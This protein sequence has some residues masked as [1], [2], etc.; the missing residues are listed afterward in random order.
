[1]QLPDNSIDHILKLFDQ[2]VDAGLDFLKQHSSELSCPVPGISAVKLLCCILDGL[3]RSISEYYGGFAVEEE[4]PTSA[5]AE[6]ETSDSREHQTLAGIYIPSKRQNPSKLKS[7]SVVRNDW[8]F[9]RRNPNSLCAVISNLFVFAF[10][11]AFG[12]SFERVETEVDLDVTGGD[13]STNAI[14]HQKIARGGDTAMEKFDALVYDLF[15]E[16]E[17]SVQ[18][19][20]TV[21]MIYSYYPN[22][23]NN[24]FEPLERLISS[25]IQNVSFLSSYVESPMASQRSLFNLFSNPHEEP[26]NAS[27]LSMIPTADTIRLSFLISVIFESQYMPNILV[28]GK[29]GVGKS[30]FLAFLSKSVGSKKWR[31]SVI[32]SVLGKPLH[33][34]NVDGEEDPRKD[35]GDYTFSTTLYHISTQLGS[36]QMQSMLGSYLMRQG[37]SILLPPTGR[38]VCHGQSHVCQKHVF[39][40]TIL[41]KYVLQ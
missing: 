25:P 30:Q 34:G 18:L 10:T 23:Y 19:P 7:A 36:Q 5:K 21:K 3:L 28:S 24:T 37:K 2:S 1:M 29:S 14:H 13:L 17:V 22:I 20:P 31:K 16:G 4:A 8:P 27:R 38:N 39:V 11:W 40:K 6:E 15:T 12:G 35:T 33:M 32:Q 26:Y 9:H 41:S